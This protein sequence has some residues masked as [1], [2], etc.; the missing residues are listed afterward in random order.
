M[1]GP[2]L[3]LISVLLVACGGET[4]E[5]IFYEAGPD[6]GTEVASDGGADLGV[7]SGP[8]PIVG[9][10]DRPGGCPSPCPTV[11]PKEG[12]AC[13]KAELECEYGSSFDAKCNIVSRCSAGKW[14]IAAPKSTC[15]APTSCPSS[16]FGPE[17]GRACPVEGS[18]CTY[19]DGVCD[20]E[21]ESAGST[22]IVWRCSTFTCKGPRPR[23]GCSCMNALVCQY[24]S[25]TL[26]EVVHGIDLACRSDVWMRPDTCR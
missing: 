8:A 2:A 11:L 26:G 12:D 4:G 3:L 1:R 16:P 17:R 20:C 21:R 15:A 14:T 19:V 6:D 7:D 25:C 18:I 22:A 23:L 5:E 13:T 24:G 9:P 10:Y